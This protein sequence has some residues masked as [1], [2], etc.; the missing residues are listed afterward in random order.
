M[1]PAQGPHRTSATEAQLDS[2]AGYHMPPTVACS[3]VT[4]VIC[5]SLRLCSWSAWYCGEG[6]WG[7][8]ESENPTRQSVDHGYIP[9]IFCLHLPCAGIP[10]MCGTMA[11]RLL[12]LGWVTH[13][14]GGVGVQALQATQLPSDRTENLPE[15][16]PVMAQCV[17]QPPKVASVRCGWLQ[18]TQCCSAEAGR[19]LVGRWGGGGGGAFIGMEDGT[20]LPDYHL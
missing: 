3:T 6:N 2:T 14:G 4:R 7:I 13:D 16:F 20:E 1:S 10:V 8:R 15:S 11:R 19:G 12:H 17:S 5:F 9:G 18:S